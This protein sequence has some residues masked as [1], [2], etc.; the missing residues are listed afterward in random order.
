MDEI[1]DF[2]EHHT[3]KS[4]NRSIKVLLGFIHLQRHADKY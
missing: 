2:Y 3:L 4:T 1:K